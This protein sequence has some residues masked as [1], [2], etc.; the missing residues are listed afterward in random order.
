MAKP[1][2][3]DLTSDIDSVGG[4]VPIVKR[5]PVA[6]V[7]SYGKTRGYLQDGRWLPGWLVWLQRRKR[8]LA[9]LALGAAGWALWRLVGAAEGEYH[10]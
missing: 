1:E 2:T 8:V 4:L 9:L 7:T 6:P 5:G 3:I 10:D